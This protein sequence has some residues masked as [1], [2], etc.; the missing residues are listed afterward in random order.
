MP[1]SSCSTVRTSVEVKLRPVRRKALSRD[2]DSGLL[3]NYFSECSKYLHSFELCLAAYASRHSLQR[4][5]S[6]SNELTLSLVLILEVGPSLWSCW[7][8]LHSFPWP[9]LAFCVCSYCHQW[10]GFHTIG[11]C[12][13]NHFNY[14]IDINRRNYPQK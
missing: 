7:P 5:F 8:E 9:C 11:F 2:M 13:F 14:T 6:S 4:A 10:L 12:L 1:V 3:M